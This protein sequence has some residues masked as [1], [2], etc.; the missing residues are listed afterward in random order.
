M[1]LFTDAIARLKLYNL[2]LYSAASNAFGL[3]GTGGMAANWR[4]HSQ[5]M[6]TVGETVATMATDAY[7]VGGSARLAWDTGTADAN[8][9]AGKL[10]GNNATL[11][12]VTALYVSTTD[13]DGV[14]ISAILATWGT[15]T[16]SV[17][18]ALRLAVVGERGQR[19]D[20]L[21]TGVVT[22]HTGYVAIP[23]S[24]VS[25]SA[26]LLAGTGVVLGFVARGDIGAAG[27]TYTLPTASAG[28]LGGVKVGT[29]L[30]IDGSGVL[31]ATG[32]LQSSEVTGTTQA[33]VVGRSYIANNASRV[34][35]T[36]PA[37][38][39]VGD[40][41]EIVGKGAG[42]WRINQNAG[43][44]ILCGFGLGGTIIGTN[45]GL[46]STSAVS[47]VE[48]VC[49]TANTTWTVVKHEV[50]AALFG[51]L[52]YFIAGR[53]IGGAN[54]ASIEN[55]DLSADTSAAISATLPA[56]RNTSGAVNSS[57][58]G[59]VAGNSLLGGAARNSIAALTF[60][61]ESAATLSATISSNRGSVGGVNSTT[62]GYFTGGDDGTNAV[63]TIQ[64]LTFSSDVLVSL[65]SGL[66]TARADMA[67]CSSS[68]RGITLG[69]AT[70]ASGASLTTSIE[71]LTYSGET[72]ASV[73]GALDTA[74]R[75]YGGANSTTK[76]YVF[77]GLTAGG[78][79]A[80]IE[81]FTFSADT[82]VTIS[83]TLATATRS[84]AAVNGAT[85]AYVAGGNDGSTFS[86]IQKFLFSGETNSTLAATLDTARQEANGV[87]GG[88]L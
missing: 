24:F 10:R 71:A 12:S 48:L 53:D 76:G 78:N 8:P 28:T 16:S 18:G 22:T 33:M 82:S 88:Y 26:T 49:T 15:G 79:T 59:Y 17:K 57:V 36:L 65:G 13:G 37:T 1:S 81:D 31:S 68:T 61:G 50:D 14:D 27:P 25:S 70:A 85:A 63:T 64:A 54:L 56:A 72:S 87:Q 21:V 4:R 74:K 52:G 44:N 41:V 69:G 23:A 66:A 3:S 55:M 80:V 58:K 51:E 77:G 2:G 42:G 75:L 32:G 11:A 43:Q 47:T 67:S 19:A 29:N 83:A 62:K 45:G 73:T 39:A 35:L 86:R 6:A 30:A 7:A 34:T 40:R 46:Q 84:V 60:A 9:G 38:S 20:F 5:D